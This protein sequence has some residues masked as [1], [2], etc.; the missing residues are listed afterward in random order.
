M[1]TNPKQELLHLT[2]SRAGRCISEQAALVVG[3]LAEF[4]FPKLM[5]GLVG[6]W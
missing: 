1:T 3:L 5:F 6:E 2:R 4:F